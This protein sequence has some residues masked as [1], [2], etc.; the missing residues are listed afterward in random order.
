MDEFFKFVVS[1][2]AGIVA[3][4]VCKWLGRHDRKR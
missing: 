1:V 4:Y 2:A 3:N